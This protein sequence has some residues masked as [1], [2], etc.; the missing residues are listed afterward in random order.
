V[1]DTAT[2]TVTR[3]PIPVGNEPFGV[4]VTPDGRKVYVANITD[5]T[6]SVISTATNT[7]T[8]SPI[9]VGT[10]PYGVAVTPDGSKVYVANR[11]DGTVS[12]IRTATNTVTGSPIPVGGFPAGVAVTLDGSK[13]YVGNHG[14]GGT[15]SVIR[16]ATNTVIGSPIPVGT[17]PYGVAVTPDGSKVYVAIYVANRGDGT[18]SVISTANGGGLSYMHSGMYGMYASQESVRQMRGT[19]PPKS[20]APKSRSATASAACSPPAAP[21]P[22]QMRCRRSPGQDFGTRSTRLRASPDRR[23]RSRG[24]KDTSGRVPEG[25]T[26]LPAEDPQLLLLGAPAWDSG[27]EHALRVGAYSSHTNRDPATR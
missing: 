23:C 8:G 10:T 4:A 5:G 3:S 18:V 26:V 21:S 19:A 17:T 14:A 13:A 9:P 25:P 20:P 7:V 11:G 12:V 27:P 22:C 2:N 15:V 6:V 24:H 16:T 1:I